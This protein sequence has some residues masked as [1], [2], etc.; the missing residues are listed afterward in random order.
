MI[1]EVVFK[2]RNQESEDNQEVT[3]CTITA[4]ANCGLIVKPDFNYGQQ[5]YRFETGNLGRG[6]IVCSPVSRILFRGWVGCQKKF[7]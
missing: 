1:L 3:L 4:D 7:S 2:C 6:M 5:P